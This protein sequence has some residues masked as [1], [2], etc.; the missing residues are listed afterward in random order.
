MLP[1]PIDPRD[2]GFRACLDLFYRAGTVYLISVF[3]Y[4]TNLQI[5]DGEVLFIIF[6]RHVSG[7]HVRITLMVELFIEHVQNSARI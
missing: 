5:R 6:D 3:L 1:L 7:L 2:T 4:H